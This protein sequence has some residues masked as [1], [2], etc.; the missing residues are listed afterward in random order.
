MLRLL[1]F[2]SFISFAAPASAQ[3][4]MASFYGPGFHGNLTANGER[5][6]RWGLTAAH[7][8]LPFGSR[9]KV[10]NQATGR[11]VVVRV[12]DDGPHVSGRIIDLSEAA[13]RKLALPSQGLARV[14]MTR[15]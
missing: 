14:C 13:F 5:F 15:M 4:G 11:S 7:R 1:T 8:S 6:N 9:V 10:V 12:N 3:C 2:L